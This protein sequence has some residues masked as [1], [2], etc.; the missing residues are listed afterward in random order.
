VAGE[1]V[2]DEEIKLEI[3]KNNFRDRFMEIDRKKQCLN[4]HNDR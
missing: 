4:E 3:A 1:F 2:L